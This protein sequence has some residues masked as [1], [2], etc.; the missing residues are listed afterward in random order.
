M[1]GRSATAALTRKHPASV[2]QLLPVCYL[3]FTRQPRACF[4]VALSRIARSNGAGETE[5]GRGQTTEKQSSGLL[6]CINVNAQTSRSH[7]ENG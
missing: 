4:I 2:T 3:P 1:I 6:E 7:Y 5:G